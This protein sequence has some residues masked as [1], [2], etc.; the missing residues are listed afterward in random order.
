MADLKSE[1]CDTIG[2]ASKNCKP[3]EKK[4]KKI[5]VWRGRALETAGGLDKKKLTRNKRG[6]IV[7]LKKSRNAKKNTWI[8][9]V[10]MARKDMKIKGFQPVTGELY[11]KAK[12]YHDKMKK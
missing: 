5:K 7:S 4:G 3:C 2:G 6:K 10:Q 11:E 9:A 12:S 1:S 8:Q